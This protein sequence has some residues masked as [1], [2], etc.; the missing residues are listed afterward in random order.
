[1]ER[2]ARVSKNA[3]VLVG[4]K[5]VT[6]GLSFL[7][8]IIIN[9]Q[10]GPVLIG[11]Y[12][13]AFVLYT[14]FQV[15]PDFGIGNITVRDVS[16]DESKLHYYFRNVVG[17]RLTLGWVAFLL[18]MATNLVA[19][20]L[21]GPGELTWVRFWAV[22]T[23]AFCLLVEQPF[24]NTLLENFIALERLTVVALVYLIL[25]IMRV[26][27]SIYV[28][29]AGFD[30]IVVVLILIYIFCY[31][32][33]I[34]HF[35]IIYRRLL[36]RQA[37]LAAGSWEKALAEAVT[38]VPEAR[39]EAP[40]EALAADVSYAVLEKA[41]AGESAPGAEGAA[42]EPA[43]GQAGEPAREEAAA[44]AERAVGA[45]A[46]AEEML[47]TGGVAAVDVPGAPRPPEAEEPAASGRGEGP[48][49]RERLGFLPE[50]WRY[51]LRS[52]WPLAV[53]SGGV[54][55]YAVIEVPILSWI[56]GDEEVGLYIA[57]AM[58][59]KAF[60][61]FTLAINMAVLPAVSKVGGKHPERLGEVWERILYYALAI[62]V[63]LAILTPVLA[64]PFLIYEGHNY[65][66]AY[67]VVWL[68]MAAMCFT[69]LTSI[70][71]P[72]FVVLD[73]QKVMTG[74]I[75]AGIGIK[76]ALDLVAIPLWG[77]T[78]AAVVVVASEA[79]VFALLAWKLSRELR[80]RPRVARF[81]GAPTAALAAL[82]AVSLALTWLL[83]RGETGL[84]RSALH[85]VIISAAVAVI[86]LALAFLSGMLK[87]SRLQELNDLLTVEEETT[88]ESAAEGEEPVGSEA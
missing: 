7:M 24:S 44:G 52:A 66:A 76:V 45:E 27:L 51:L 28:V 17:L 26:A 50:F 23:I 31:L 3:V 40:Y 38:H 6:S 36:R 42:G 19:T 25:G 65:I 33:S 11:I 70:S 56:K 8:A 58:F 78:G 68:T 75:A 22:F 54:I 37:H 41:G 63:P 39:G 29:L 71:F 72:F 15:L 79:A 10:L 55:I 2:V 30:H 21:Q 88:E 85:A 5:L 87:K 83:V 64:R 61:F 49:P 34:A 16:Q 86:Y 67:H 48:S 47:A 82:Y 80:H 73:K 12:N 43:P 20:A 35:Y 60:V 84:G 1:M 9:R 59:A 18:L 13:Y 53:L 57:A 77:Y 32:Y 69:F 14:I 62:V 74:V 81:A 46:A 4:A